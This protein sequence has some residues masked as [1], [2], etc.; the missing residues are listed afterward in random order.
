MFNEENL[1]I[2]NNFYKK[3]GFTLVEILIVISLTVILAAA[4]FPIYSNLQLHTR[5]SEEST[6][7]ERVMIMA[8][9]TARGGRDDSNFGIYFN[10]VQSP[11]TYTYYK[12]TS[13]ATRDESLDQVYR[14]ESTTLA[15]ATTWPG[16]EVNFHRGTGLPDQA[17]SITLKQFD[18]D[19]K[20]ISINEL[21]ITTV[22]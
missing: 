12:G 16:N 7:I 5:A 14:F 3:N 13:Y 22:Q 8:R 15:A 4:S 1:F 20:I 11:N 21:G 18:Q 10:S 6:R 2:F 9:E 17:G 19:V